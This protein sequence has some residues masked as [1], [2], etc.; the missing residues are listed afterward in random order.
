[1]APGIN[2]DVNVDLLPHD[3]GDSFVSLQHPEMQNFFLKFISNFNQLILV[4]LFVSPMMTRA[5]RPQ[6][7]EIHQR[8]TCNLGTFIFHI[9]HNWGSLEL[10]LSGA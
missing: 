7:T 4:H 2:D 3:R 8:T 6:K 9:C 1:M 10:G 5:A